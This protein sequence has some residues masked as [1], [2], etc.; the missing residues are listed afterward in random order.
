MIE[1]RPESRGLMGI[2]ATVC[3]GLPLIS[4][5]VRL[6]STGDRI[7]K[8]EGVFSGTLS[9][10]FNTYSPAKSTGSNALKF[11]DVVLDAKRRG[12]TVSS[13]F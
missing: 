13:I 8:I 7:L 11:S 2:E 6:Q 3:A 12:F 4:T 10:C 9:Y 5:L 1:S